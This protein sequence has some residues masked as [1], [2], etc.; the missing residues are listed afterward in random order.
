MGASSISSWAAGV[1]Q[2]ATFVV[3]SFR[4]NRL[5]TVVLLLTLTIAVAAN[6]A[7]FSVANAVLFRPLNVP[8]ADRIVRL[9][10][11]APQ[12]VFPLAP[13]PLASFWLQQSGVFEVVAAH[14]LDFANLVGT[15]RP[16]LLA[17][18]RVSHQFLPLYGAPLLHG[19]AFSEEDDRPN[20]P[21]VVVISHDL[22]QRQ[23]GGSPA[24]DQQI[25][26]GGES[27]R[28]IGIV[29][30]GFAP[31]HLAQVPDAWL[32]LRLDPRNPRAAGEF[33]YVTARLKPGTDL[34]QAN[35]Q[36]GVA[37][38]EFRRQAPRALPPQASFTAQP[39][40]EVVVGEARPSIFVLGVAAGLVLLIAC[41]NVTSLMLIRGSRRVREMAVRTA[42]GA[43]RGR[44]FRLLLTETLTL[45]LVAALLGLYLGR[46]GI[47]V[48]LAAHPDS[49]PMTLVNNDPSLPRIGSHGSAVVLDWRVAAFTLALAIG[50]TVVCGLI[51]ALRVSRRDRQAAADLSGSNA[52][53]GVVPNR[54][55]AVL[56]TGEIALALTLLVGAWLLIRSSLNLRAV[57]PGYET[58]NVLT[59]RMSM[60]GTSFQTR[61][62][63]EQLTRRGIQA[64]EHVSG[65]EVAST[66][67]C[68]PLETVWQL[69]FRVAGRPGGPGPTGVGGWTFISP[70]YFTV[71]RI[72]LLRG[73]DFTERDAA[74]A[75]G[76][77]IINQEMARRFWPT[78]DP[79]NDQ[80]VIG[81]GVRPD[82]NADPVRQV[83]GI[84]GDVRDENLTE[85]PR[86]AMYVPVAQVPDGVTALNL[87][88]LPLVWIARTT[89]EPHTLVPAIDRAL[90]TASDGLP[91]A[92][93]R[94]MDEI[95]AESVARTRLY[96][97][98]LTVFA[99]VALALATV[100]I[101]G[102]IAYAVY[103]RTHETGVRIA[104]GATPSAIRRRFF[105]RGLTLVVIG[106][107]AGAVATFNATRALA[108]FV[109]GVS[110]RDPVVFV[111][112][113]LLLT[114]VA[115]VAVWIPAQQAARMSALDALRTE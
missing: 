100:G 78:G 15:S 69:P 98:L 92:R 58:H 94:T 22:W 39:L 10:G 33:S 110:P 68:M 108:G 103:Q 9:V 7:V 47:D 72:P 50:V 41:A 1:W 105:V 55:H 23:F 19:R 30:P 65:V 17:I 34:A 114:V 25:R 93:V 51:P 21:P 82:Y 62:G 5:F 11:T 101:Y 53:A 89:V 97:L 83:I 24:L 42:L 46:A 56:V 63:I 74:D 76:V 52:G 6:S 73:R 106:V 4:T 40:I 26:L 59:M 2:D 111:S 61:A 95:A 38:A 60:A 86:P 84:V 87:K 77:V 66:T 32:P 29:A 85:K 13:P 54:L 36:L 64:V 49:N 67:C 27:L 80:L 35:A 18:G 57:D 31:E 12:G 28:V 109:F 113:S 3:R 81:R 75:P 70:G 45:C 99:V 20:G 91:V 104:L 14:R 71:F 115:L 48:L 90:Q 8:H 96:T 43:S 102:L 16:E 112:A 79:L 107:A 88:L 37:A 44:V